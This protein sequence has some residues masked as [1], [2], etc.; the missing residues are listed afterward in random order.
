MHT[1]VNVLFDHLW[2]NY[3]EVT[4]SAKQVHEVL[5]KGQ[6][7]IN[8]HVAFRTF[9]IEKVNLDKLAAHF[10]ALGYVAKGDYDFEKKKLKA[11]H[12]EHE[13]PTLPKVFI[14]ELLVEEFPEDIQQIIHKMVDQ[15]DA[16]LVTAD[17]FL[18]SGAQ[19]Q[20]SYDEYLR[21]LQESEYAAWMSAY[22]YRANH[23]TVSINHLGED[24]SIENVNQV[25]KD[26]GF[27]L[28]ASGGEI[29]G[30]PDVF[31]EQS[32]TMAD[33][34]NVQFSDQLAE[35]PSCFYEFARRYTLPNGEIYTG[36][37]AASADKIFEST[38]VNA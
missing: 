32:S 1:N 17:N 37:V 26:A 6:T 12:F 4:P 23:F 27:V 15:L 18:Y 35:I 29:K 13:D 21:L 28:N 16:S 2:Q 36:F 10:E 38:N 24:E 14:S 7:L 11:K 19:W 20:V 30:S 9:N 34:T 5:G 33:K 31:L 3:L 22:G 8:D 25:L